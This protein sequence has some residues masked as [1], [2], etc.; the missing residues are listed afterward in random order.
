MKSPKS[1]IRI[2]R[3]KAIEGGVSTILGYSGYILT[4]KAIYNCFYEEG[5]TRDT[6][7][8]K[9]IHTWQRLD[10]IVAIRT[11]IYAVYPETKAELNS[12]EAEA[13]IGEDIIP[14]L[15]PESVRGVSA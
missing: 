2:V 13:K 9:Y 1:M 7:I 11:G 4:Q 5:F 10:L 8:A 3:A 6:T 14:I 12:V 15:S